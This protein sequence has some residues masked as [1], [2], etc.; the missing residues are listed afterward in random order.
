MKII[1][2]TPTT[3]T[4]GKH[5]ATGAFIPEATHFLKHHAQPTSR[6][7]KIDNTKSKPEMKAAVLMALGQHKDLDGVAFFCHGFKAGIQFGFRVEDV[8]VLAK[9]LAASLGA[10]PATGSES[11]RDI[12]TFYACDAARDSDQDRSDDLEEFGGDGGF[13]DLVRDALC[14]QGRIYCHV[15]AHT[16][17][18]HTTINPDVRRFRGGGSA[19]GGPGGYYLVPRKKELWSKW[20]AA[21]KTSFRYDFPYLSTAEIH[22]RLQVR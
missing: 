11:G 3:N 22:R 4:E 5:D 20:V 8:P 17:A 7:I 15:D 2:F 9:V 14:A 10:A 13:A 6:L 18:A 12:I 1:A 21:L 19:V 16:S